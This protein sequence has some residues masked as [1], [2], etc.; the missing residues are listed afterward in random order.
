M[1]AAVTCTTVAATCMV[2]VVVATCIADVVCHDTRFR[3]TIFLLTSLYL[4]LFHSIWYSQFWAKSMTSRIS[5]NLSIPW[6]ISSGHLS[7]RPVSYSTSFSCAQPSPLWAYNTFL[8]LPYL[9]S[10]LSLVLSLHFHSISAHNLFSS[11][12]FVS[13]LF[14]SILLISMSA[15]DLVILYIYKPLYD[16]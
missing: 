10:F 9:S 4:L 16:W 5:C 15:R 6:P 11:L 13:V 2:A 12:H 1:A 7:A 3:L 14:F 8:Y